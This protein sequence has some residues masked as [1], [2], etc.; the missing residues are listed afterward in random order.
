M[1][2]DTELHFTDKV[3]ADRQVVAT[4]GERFPR[5]EVYVCVSGGRA[6]GRLFS[7]HKPSVDEGHPGDPAHGV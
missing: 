7:H 1:P 5:L 4:V 3:M 2:E 6:S